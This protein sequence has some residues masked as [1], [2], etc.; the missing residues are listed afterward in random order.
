MDPHVHKL[1]V[2][3]FYCFT[4]EKIGR[5]SFAQVYKGYHRLTKQE[6]AVKVID[7]EKVWTIFSR[8]IRYA[9]S[10]RF[11]LTKNNTKLAEHMRSEMEIMKGLKHENVVELLDARMVCHVKL[12]IFEPSSNGEYRE[13]ITI[14]IWFSNIVPVYTLHLCLCSSLI[15][16][17][18]GD[19]HKFLSEQ[20]E[21]RL[22]ESRA[23]HF[24][25]QL[26]KRILRFFSH[27]SWRRVSSA[28]GLRFLRSRK[29]IHR[30][31]KVFV[32]IDSVLFTAL[33]VVF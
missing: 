17:P 28:C 10:L 15:V 27:V 5:G 31:L 3:E 22:S 19:F 2:G 16:F 25:R 30:D 24:L 12:D 9:S 26:G 8:L 21:H 14:F 7:M 32:Y 11:Q 1:E 33:T 29:I 23:R 13:T 20:P 18:G 4:N 6:V